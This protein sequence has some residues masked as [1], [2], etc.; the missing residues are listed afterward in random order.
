MTYIKSTL[1]GIG[2]LGITVLMSVG[3]LVIKY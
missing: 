1:A 2:A 3:F